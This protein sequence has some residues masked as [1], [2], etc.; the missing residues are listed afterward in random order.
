MGEQHS[1]T[2][3]TGDATTLFQKM[4]ADIEMLTWEDSLPDARYWFDSRV[5]Y[6]CWFDSRVCYLCVGVS[7][8]L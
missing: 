8:L 1:H 7:D 6:L 5:C 4:L 2:W 3:Y